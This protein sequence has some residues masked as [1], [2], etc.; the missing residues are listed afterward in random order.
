M[1]LGVCHLGQKKSLIVR[2]FVFRE[3]FNSYYLLFEVGLGMFDDLDARGPLEVA[4]SLI[5]GEVHHPDVGIEPFEGL[6]R[7]L[8]YFGGPIIMGG[9][10]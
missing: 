4:N 8:A 5:L 2:T 10:C 1:V 7:P 9:H 6:H 3:L